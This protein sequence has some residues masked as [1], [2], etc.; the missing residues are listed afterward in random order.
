MWESWQTRWLC[1][2]TLL[3]GQTSVKSKTRLK[4]KVG[5][6]IDIGAADTLLAEEGSYQVSVNEEKLLC[7]SAVTKVK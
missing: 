2:Q 5:Q 3:R 4:L 6:P 7:C 1:G